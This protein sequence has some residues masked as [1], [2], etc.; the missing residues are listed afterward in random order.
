[1]TGYQL[2][3]NFY[4]SFANHDIDGMLA[5]YADD[6]IFTD[7]AF[8]RLEGKDAHDMWRML[9]SRGGDTTEVTLVDVSTTD[10]D[11]GTAEWWARYNYGAGKR[12]V[13]NQ[14]SA[15]FLIRDGKIVEHTDRFDLWKWSRQALGLNGLLLGWTPFM[16]SRIQETTAGLLKAFQNKSA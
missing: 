9:L 12:P 16:R 5:C 15:S 13:I 10:E 7:P 11:R 2:I 6:V 4:R 1:M 8:G 3:T 14:V